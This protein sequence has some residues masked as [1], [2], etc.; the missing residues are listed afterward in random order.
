MDI[1]AFVHLERGRSFAPKAFKAFG[2]S[3]RNPHHWRRL[4]SCL[5]EVIYAERRGAPIKWT[6]AKQLG[7]LADADSVQR[8]NE[9]LT[10]E[11]IWSRLKRMNP[12]YK[13]MSFD[14]WRRRYRQASRA[15]ALP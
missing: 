11:Q 5:A 15:L 8:H 2:L 1:G 12:A 3:P 9:S 4:L 6:A 14:N 10:Q 13:N 7:L